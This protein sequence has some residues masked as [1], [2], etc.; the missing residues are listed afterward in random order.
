MIS[1][2]NRKKNRE[3]IEQLT[4]NINLLKSSLN[5]TEKSKDLILDEF[6]QTHNVID[7]LIQNEKIQEKL[8]CYIEIERVN[9]SAE[10]KQ[11]PKQKQK[12][13]INDNLSIAKLKFIDNTIDKK[14][15]SIQ[16]NH[17]YFTQLVA[18]KMQINYNIN[19]Q[20]MILDQ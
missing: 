2:N 1:I 5:Q 15:I 6:K 7:K 18:I 10:Q 19:Y 13:I 3:V 11:K 14:S 8:K 12:Q 20:Q 17:S 16:W 9:E 4:N